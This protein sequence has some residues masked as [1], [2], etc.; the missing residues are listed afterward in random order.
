MLRQNFLNRIPKF[1]Q[2]LGFQ[3]FSFSSSGFL[4]SGH[5]K[6][7]KIKHKKAENDRSK[8]LR[9]GKLSQAIALAVR[10]NG[11]NPCNN[12]RLAAYLEEA[13]KFSLTKAVIENAIKKGSGIGNKDAQTLN[14][15][16]YESM[17]PSGVGIIVETITDN[18]SR[19]AA[20]VK[21]V[22]R[23]HNASLSDVQYLFDKKGKLELNAPKEYTEDVFDKV[24]ED[25][26]EAG[27]DDI[28]EQKFE[29]EDEKTEDEGD[30]VALTKTNNLSKATEYF[31]KKGYHITD[32][33]ISYVPQPGNAVEPSEDHNEELQDLIEKL[34]DL[35]DV[36]DVYTNIKQRYMD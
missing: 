5:N 1:A 4:L 25:A 31:R 21:N 16:I 22:L 27:A 12:V 33:S 35:D 11:P 20:F 18:R 2:Q 26:I 9:I 6:W 14:E 24:V 23:K 15:V 8:S 32:A 30:F 29:S 7:S 13:K 10:E 28:Y 3:K 36:V 17:H 19:T 34:C